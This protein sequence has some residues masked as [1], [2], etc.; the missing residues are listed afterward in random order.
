MPS[1]S[2]P[3]CPSS[4][5]G[6]ELLPGEAKACKRSKVEPD[7]LKKKKVIK[8]DQTWFMFQHGTIFRVANT[9]LD[10]NDAMV[11]KMSKA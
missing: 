5:T 10:S 8:I 3:T 2:S 6:G 9:L 4:R 11:Q 7:L 1:R